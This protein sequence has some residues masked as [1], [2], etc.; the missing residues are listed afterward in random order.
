MRQPGYGR[1]WLSCRHQL[2]TI[3]SVAASSPESRPLPPFLLMTGA[4]GARKTWSLFRSHCLQ[5]SRVR[6]KPGQALVADPD[7]HFAGGYHL[8]RSGS[9][10][11]VAGDPMPLPSS[12]R[13][14][15]SRET[16][17][18]RRSSSGV[19]S[20]HQHLVQRVATQL[21]AQRRGDEQINANAG[22]PYVGLHRDEGVGI[23]FIHFG[24]TPVDGLT[25]RG[26]G[27][28][29]TRLH[30]RIAA[31]HRLHHHDTSA[32]ARTWPASS[33]TR[34]RGERC[35]L[36]RQHRLHRHGAGRAHHQHQGR[37]CARQRAS[38]RSSPPSTGP[39]RTRT[40]TA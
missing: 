21:H 4:N 28:L 12:A 22:T 13:H 39:C 18:R 1:E 29:R 5:R 3:A 40:T 20:A 32:T 19:G 7:H 8:S 6:E 36:E 14:R 38:R 31:T 15:S 2:G 23:A 25:T 17:T 35:E 33:R 34:R 10:T 11:R 37:E 27:H 24:A 16:S 9:S 30:V 26:H